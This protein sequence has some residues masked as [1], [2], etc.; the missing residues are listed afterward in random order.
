MTFRHGDRVHYPGAV[1]DVGTVTREGDHP[2]FVVFWDLVDHGLPGV[3]ECEPDGMLTTVA[4]GRLVL[5]HRHASEALAN[6]RA[7]WAR[8][9]FEELMAADERGAR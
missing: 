2:Q 3:D 6:R 5:A 8:R 9:R 4:G 1:R 7:E